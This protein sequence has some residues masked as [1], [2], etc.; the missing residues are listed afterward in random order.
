MTMI[1][2]RTN[3]TRRE[4]Q[5]EVD[6]I[7]DNFFSGGEEASSGVWTPRVD[8]V[9]ADDTFRIVLDLPGVPKDDIKINVQDGT[10]TVRGTRNAQSTDEEVDF[11]HI[12]RPF[13]SFYRSFQLPRS[14]DTDSIEAAYD[15]G[16]LTVTIPKKEKNTARH[17][18]VNG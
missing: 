12:E 10:L 15:N 17:I 9:E 7:F 8:L 3:R 5:R 11:V 6:S 2:R 13:G 1:T 14:I 16:V 18:Q 4:L